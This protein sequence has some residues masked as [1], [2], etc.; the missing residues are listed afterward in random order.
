MTDQM[1]PDVGFSD[2]TSQRTP[3]VLVLDGSSSMA[4]APIDQLNDGLKILEKELKSNPMTSLRVQVLVIQIGGHEDAKVI[5]DWCDAIDFVAPTVEANGTTPLGR[6]MAMA[7]DKIEE[8]KRNYDANG[9]SSTRPWIIVLSDGAP[10]DYGWE[11][12]ATRCRDA[13]SRKKVV[14][15]PIGTEDADMDALGS[16]SNKSAKKLK[17]LQ[18]NELFVWLSRSMTAVSSSSPGE[19]VQLPADNWSE[20]EA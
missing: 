3:C 13:E 10:N 18:F 15:Y 17:G 11:D 7:L 4:G 6:G 19:K 14:I 9:I 1:I 20:V 2:N 12:V 16:F 5:H 8:Q